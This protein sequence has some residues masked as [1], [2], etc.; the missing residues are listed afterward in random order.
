VLGLMASLASGLGLFREE[1]R[2]NALRGLALGA[3]AALLPTGLAVLTLVAL[4]Q[5]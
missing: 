2:R 4:S 1:H 5:P 3:L